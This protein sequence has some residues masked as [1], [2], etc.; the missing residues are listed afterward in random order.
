MEAGGNGVGEEPQK[1]M[2]LMEEEEPAVVAAGTESPRPDPESYAR[3]Y[4]LEAL[5]RAVRQNTIVFLETGSGKTLI[6]VMLL[7]AYAHAIRK[8]SRRIAIFLVP[9]V[10]L[11]SQVSLPF[12]SLPFPSLPSAPPHFPLY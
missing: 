12:P 6:A 8:P 3:S 10:V 2:K 11:V 5:E 1:K 7:R 9:T 4:Q